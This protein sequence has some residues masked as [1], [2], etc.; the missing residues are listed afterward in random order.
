MLRSFATF[1]VL[2]SFIA[3]SWGQDSWPISKE[4]RASAAH[5]SE[6]Y[7]LDAD[8]TSRVA[9]IEA[10]LERHLANISGLR[11]SEPDQYLQKLKAAYLGREHSIR[12]TL[13]LDQAR[14]YRRDMMWMRKIR[15]EKRI[16]LIREGRSLL[17]AEEEAHALKWEPQPQD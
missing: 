10:R 16:L 2:F 8:Q 9:Q 5:F 11:K 7:E 15:A 1:L 14:T 4:A 17:E 12:A 13:E 3:I 6:I